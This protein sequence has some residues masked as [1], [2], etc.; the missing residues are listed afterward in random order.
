MKK[1]YISLLLF[2]LSFKNIKY[3]ILFL[4]SLF[5]K[6]I[7]RKFLLSHVNYY[8]EKIKKL[9]KKIKPDLRFKLLDKKEI[10]ENE[11]IIG[12][13]KI[14]LATGYIHIN[15]NSDWNL[16]FDDSEQLTSLHRWN[17]L[18]I[19]ATEKGTKINFQWGIKLIRSYLNSQ[20]P[21]P[22]GIASESYTISERI[23]N[24]IIF[25]KYYTNSWHALPIDIQDS[26]KTMLFNLKDRIEYSDPELN[27]NHIVNNARAF[28]LAGHSLR[29]REFIFLGREILR[30]LLPK[31]VD[32]KGFLREGSSHYQF[33]FTRW[34]IEIQI[35]SIDTND[36]ETL[37]ILRPYLKN[38]IDCC[39]FF[40]V[41]DGLGKS[42][43]PIIGDISPDFNIE[44]LIDL[45]KIENIFSDHHRKSTNSTY[46][47]WAKM[48]KRFNDENKS[49]FNSHDLETTN[50]SGNTEWSRYDFLEWTLFC[51][52]ESP[53]GEA[54][55]SHSHYDLS[56]FVLFFRGEEVVIDPGRLNYKNRYSNDIKAQSHSTVCLNGMP[57]SL[58]KCDRYLP[59]NYKKTNVTFRKISN[60][61]MLSFF[62]SHDGFSRILNKK[63]MHN[64]NITLKKNEVIVEDEITGNGSFLMENNIVFPINDNVSENLDKSGQY[65]DTKFSIS[66]KID[67]LLAMRINETKVTP[68]LYTSKKNQNIISRS[69]EY[70]IS[71]P[72]LLIRKTKSISLPLK[73]DYSIK[74]N[75]K[76]I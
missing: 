6:I 31:L 69:K 40:I 10:F 27:S 17:W 5:L 64:R 74:I 75:Y 39:R 18:L 46:L 7:K 26:L 38:L 72:S 8:P 48:I 68:E 4:L 45:T 59:E 51:H 14:K 11:F 34:I 20:S 3:L 19:A 62:I 50:C 15:S 42:K 47:G 23:S 44:W 71:L 66:P 49:Y 70:G 56:S 73:M 2:H 12:S 1:E 21:L 41:F 43:I 67:I 24:S 28:I 60:K 61:N 22:S 53:A 65:K 13:N 30:D 29:L 36:K 63:I 58:R 55:P 32:D 76:T 9:H 33:L 25:T 35:I 57:P 52:H 54:I 16:S 37:N